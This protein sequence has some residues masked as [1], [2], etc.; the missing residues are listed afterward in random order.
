[1]VY[2]KAITSAAGYDLTAGNETFDLSTNVSRFS[3]WTI[4]ILLA[5]VTYPAAEDDGVFKI[6]QSIGGV[7]WFDIVGLASQTFAAG[8]NLTFNLIDINT[9]FLRV[10]YTQNSVDSGT[11]TSITLLGKT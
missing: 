5:G 4:E 9:N 1:M 10:D 8:D 2:S 6:Q 7:E 11:I 3:K